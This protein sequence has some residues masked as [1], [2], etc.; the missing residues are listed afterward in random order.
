MEN[1]TEYLMSK[2]IGKTVS[3]K[4]KREPKKQKVIK[5]VGPKD[6][7]PEDTEPKAILKRSPI[8][9]IDN[10]GNYDI[11]DN[12]LL[13][14]AAEKCIQTGLA[15]KTLAEAGIG[16]VAAALLMC[17]QF[18]LPQ[19]A[20]AQMA[21]IHGRLTVFGTLYTAL[22]QRHPNFGEIKT[23][24]VDE[25][26]EE[27]CLENKNLKADVYACV[28]QV[29][30]KSRDHHQIQARV[31]FNEYYF[32][33]DDAIAAGLY[34]EKPTDKEKYKP[35][36][37][38]TKDMLYHKTKARAFSREYASALEGVEMHEDIVE[39]ISTPRDVN[40]KTTPENTLAMESLEA[41]IKG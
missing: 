26:S 23:V 1:K 5:D 33:L 16:A 36:Q 4:K 12:T 14:L 10:K 40:S 27:I 30:P 3:T 24:F 6:K 13:G 17:K 32:T 2:H 8:L 22:A 20:M 37:K 29:Y 21:Y 41:S 28:M 18:A 31:Q 38:Y 9:V 34:K 25:K 7:Q 39:A 35:W 11:Q 15:P 19:K